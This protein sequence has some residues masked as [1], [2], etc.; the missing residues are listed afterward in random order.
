VILDEPFSGLDPL[1]VETMRDVI[2]EQN[3]RGCTIILSTHM[4]AEA[5]KLCDAVC[6]IEGGHKVLDGTLADVRANFPLKSVR[7]AYADGREPPA[8]LPGVAHR[9]F[10]D[11]SW[12][13]TLESGADTDAV[14]DALRAGGQLSL[15]AANR[16]A[17]DEIFLS[18]V[19]ERRAAAGTEAAS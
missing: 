12:R 9:V 13:L 10:Q 16:P 4:L 7:A 14:L 17:L 18:V 1:N 11:D 15:F 5:E 2:R 8:R 6:L 3:A 19:R